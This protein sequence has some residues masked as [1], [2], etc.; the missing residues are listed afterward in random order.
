MCFMVDITRVQVCHS[1][2]HYAIRN[3]QLMD[4]DFAMRNADGW[5]NVK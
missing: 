5:E 1:K 4:A 3:T 2:L